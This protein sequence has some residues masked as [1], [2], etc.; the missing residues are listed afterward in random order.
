TVLH[1]YLVKADTHLR[2]SIPVEVRVAISLSAL[3][4]VA[5]YRL[6][7]KPF[8]VQRCT[9]CVIL[10]EFCNALLSSNLR[11]RL[12]RFPKGDQLTEVVRGFEE[13]WGFPG[14][15]DGTHIPICPPA[16]NSRDYFNRKGWASI[17]MQATC[18]FEYKFTSVNIGWPGSV[19]DARVF[20]NSE[21]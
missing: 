19:H 14:A 15:I 10:H 21:I 12:L 16:E 7:G 9:V 2:K 6:I 4:S 13:E 1:P 20:S 3:G 18:D 11:K 8:G 17:V 5:E